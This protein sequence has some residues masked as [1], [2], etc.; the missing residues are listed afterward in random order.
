LGGTA[1]DILLPLDL[2]AGV[3]CFTG[4]AVSLEEMRIVKREMR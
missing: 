2:G 1:G 4:S 3:F